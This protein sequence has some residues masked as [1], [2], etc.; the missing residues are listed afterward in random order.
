[1]G[2]RYAEALDHLSEVFLQ[3]GLLAALPVTNLE[4]EKTCQ[5]GE[6]NKF[7]VSH[8]EETK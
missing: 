2:R 5:E 4:P 1:V 8:S 7:S 3:T 6:M